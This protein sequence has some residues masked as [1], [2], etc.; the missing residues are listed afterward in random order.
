MRT[1]RCPWT[2]SSPALGIGGHCA[3]GPAKSRRSSSKTCKTMRIFIIENVFRGRFAAQL[4]NSPGYR[5][6]LRE[7]AWA[8]AIFDSGERRCEDRVD[9][10]VGRQPAR[11]NRMPA[12]HIVMPPPAKNE[13]HSERIVT[14]NPHSPSAAPASRSHSRSGRR[15]EAPASPLAVPV[16]SHGRKR[17]RKFMQD[18][19]GAPDCFLALLNSI[20][21]QPHTLQNSG[22]GFVGESGTYL[23]GVMEHGRNLNCVAAA[24]WAGGVCLCEV[25][26]WLEGAG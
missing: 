22:P 26:G 21:R 18:H 17:P 23:S 25:V 16:L 1:R 10:T 8:Q 3:G 13:C 14:S 11:H 6:R 4:G 24:H 15:I 19:V 2:I 7:I 20:L 9:Y 12:E 5:D